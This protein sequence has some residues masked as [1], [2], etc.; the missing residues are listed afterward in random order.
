MCDEIESDSLPLLIKTANNRNNHG[1]NRD[2]FIPNPSS[3]N[4]THLEMYKFLGHLLGY[5]IRTLCPLPLHFPPIF[6][7]QL[8]NDELSERDLKGFD[9]YSW[10]IIE[11]LK[12]QSKKLSEDEFDAV[13]EEVFVTRLSDASEAELKP[14]GRNVKVT[15]ANL[16]EYVSLLLQVRFNEYAAQ[17][18]AIRDGVDFVIPLNMLKLLTWDEIETRA[19]G[20]KALDID[21]LKNIT[22]YYGC[23]ADN[24]FVQRFWRV[25]AD[26]TE[27]E[28]TLYLKFVWGRSRLPYDT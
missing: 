11:D 10:Q 16:D 12:K 7:K 14:N 13:V 1:E 18:K 22:E 8:I 26:L 21:K 17:I 25:L 6:W 20:D 27:E 3:K 24:E 2:C 4:P 23:S 19:C 5:A 9:T 15:K 28:Q